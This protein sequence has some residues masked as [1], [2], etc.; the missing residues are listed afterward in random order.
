MQDS[1]TVNVDFSGGLDLVFD[2]K[3]EIKLELT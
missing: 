1:I 2:G 3:N